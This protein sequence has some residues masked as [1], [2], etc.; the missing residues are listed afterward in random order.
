MQEICL[1]SERPALVDDE[2]YGRVNQHS[3]HVTSNGYVASRV[4]GKIVLLHRFLLGLGPGQKTQVDHAN[5]DRLDNRKLNLRF[6]TSRQN[7][8]NTGAKGYWKRGK[9]YRAAIKLE[10]RVMNLGTWDDPRM[11]RAIYL[12]AKQLFHPLPEVISDEC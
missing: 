9:K 6:V 11:A 4:E 1:G 10:D 12:V 7:H 5:R 3:W 2:D 8:W